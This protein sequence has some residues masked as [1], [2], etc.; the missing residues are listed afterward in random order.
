MLNAPHAI[1]VN[2][3][4]VITE[5]LSVSVGVPFIWAAWG[6]PSPQS[7]GS[8]KRA[9]EN[10]RGIGDITATGRYWILPTSRFKSGNI[11]AGLLVKTPSGNPG[12]KD[13]FPDSAGNNNAPRYV[14]QSVQPGDGGWGIMFELNTSDAA[15]CQ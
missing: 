13:T 2:V 9:N 14:D 8:A 6:I 7:R 10:G 3:S 11:Q 1:D 5:R 4:R 12:Y 15:L